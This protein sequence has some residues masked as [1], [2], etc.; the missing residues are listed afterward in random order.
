MAESFVLSLAGAGV[1]IAATFAALPLIISFTPVHIPR[2][3][4][5]PSIFARLAC[6][7]PSSG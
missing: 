7:S 6:A 5:P 1:G 3:K 2:S 4:K